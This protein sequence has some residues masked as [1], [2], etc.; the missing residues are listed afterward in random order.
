MQLVNSDNKNLSIV[1]RNSSKVLHLD[2]D[3][4]IIHL[5][6]ADGSIDPNAEC[7]VLVSFIPNTINA[8]AYVF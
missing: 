1:G 6:S 3:N 7:V 8:N 5:V 2:V 4:Y